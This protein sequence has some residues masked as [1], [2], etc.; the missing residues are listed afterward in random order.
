MTKPKILLVDDEE[1]VRIAGKYALETWFSVTA[2]ENTAKAR[3]LLQKE[4]FNL[5]L[6]DIFITGEGQEGSIELLKFI[7]K[8]YPAI[9][10]VIL[11]GT[12]SWMQKWDELKQLGASA[13]L[14]K[15]FSMEKIKEIIDKCLN[16]EKIDNVWQ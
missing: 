2:V 11:S 15:P 10:V 1:T 14:S 12:V 6:L 3:E 8:E 7:N 5:I 16:G 9:P 4:T 13:F